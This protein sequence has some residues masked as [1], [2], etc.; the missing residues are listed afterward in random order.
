MP[1]A[2]GP[3]AQQWRPPRP[4]PDP[5]AP[6]LGDG[7]RDTSPAPRSPSSRAR[8]RPGCRAPGRHPARSRAPCHPYARRRSRAK[9]Q[10]A[11]QPDSAANPERPLRPRPSGAREARCNRHA[12]AERGRGRRHPLAPNSVSAAAARPGRG[13]PGPG[14]S[15]SRRR[16][17]RTTTSGRPRVGR[18]WGG[19][20]ARGGAR[21]GRGGG[22]GG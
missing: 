16:R 5:F 14:V 20:T 19:G 8:P 11:R 17:R 13:P 7:D 4:Q 10:D 6:A 12:P 9:E 2:E 15:R 22:P 1:A 21:G 3:G 18:G